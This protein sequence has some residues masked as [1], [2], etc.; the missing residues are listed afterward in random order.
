MNV[1]GTELSEEVKVEN[2]E[3]SKSD[4]KSTH[5]NKYTSLQRPTGKLIHANNQ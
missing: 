5:E 3:Q 2:T 4:N 1:A